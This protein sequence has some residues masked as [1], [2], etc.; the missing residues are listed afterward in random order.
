MKTMLL[1]T[2]LV[3]TS[4]CCHRSVDLSLNGHKPETL[5]ANIE[6]IG[7][8]WKVSTS[9]PLG[10]WQARL[11]NEESEVKIDSSGPRPVAFWFIS[12]QRM[13]QSR[14]MRLDLYSPNGQSPVATLE[15]KPLYPGQKFIEGVLNVVYWG[16]RPGI[17]Y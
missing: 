12:S 13:H 2:A 5:T 1:L 3:S 10:K 17:R 7:N 11:E 14:P 16:E 6:N 8:A 4:I 15:L 9:L